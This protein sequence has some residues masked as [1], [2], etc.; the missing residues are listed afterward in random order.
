MGSSGEIVVLDDDEVVVVESSDEEIQPA[1][2]RCGREALTLCAAGSIPDSL[3][4]P[5]G[6]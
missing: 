5:A 6:A 3:V 1:K 2:K 4:P